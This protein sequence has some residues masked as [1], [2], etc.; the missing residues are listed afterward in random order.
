M[1]ETGN[2]RKSPSPFCRTAPET[3]TVS[4]R[5]MLPAAV[6]TVV[7]PSY[8]HLKLQ[9]QQRCAY[10]QRNHPISGASVSAPGRI[11]LQPNTLYYKTEIECRPSLSDRPISTSPSSPTTCRLATK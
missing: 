9:R 8:S 1:I 11:N 5:Y 4:S 10:F 3:R 6:G 2:H 7:V